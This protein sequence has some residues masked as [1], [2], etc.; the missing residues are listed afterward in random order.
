MSKRSHAIVIVGDAEAEDVRRHR[1]AYLRQGFDVVVIPLP[2]DDAGRVV[3]GA[4]LGG[5]GGEV[6]DVFA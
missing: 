2:K 6:V 5:M 4:Y 1:D 3:L